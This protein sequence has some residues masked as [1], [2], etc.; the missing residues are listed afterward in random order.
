[1]DHQHSSSK[2]RHLTA[3]RDKTTKKNGAE[4]KITGNMIKEGKRSQ[5]DE[6]SSVNTHSR[7]DKDIA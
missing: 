7:S 1:V 4:K 6:R 5:T 3:E 2:F